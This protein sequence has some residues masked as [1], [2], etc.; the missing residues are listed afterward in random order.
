M[1]CYVL[2]LE[3][4]K[5]VGLIVWAVCVV[6]WAGLWFWKFG[7]SLVACSLWFV[8]WLVLVCF[9]LFGQCVCFGV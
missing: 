5:P 8:F 1:F 2:C 6:F 4:V 3:F 7:V 9:C